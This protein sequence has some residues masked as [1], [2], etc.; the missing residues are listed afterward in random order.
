MPKPRKALL[1][2][3]D[4]ELWIPVMQEI[5]HH[6]DKNTL[7]KINKWLPLFRKPEKRVHLI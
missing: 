7:A 5:F 2:L 4:T 6:T 1:S 3:E